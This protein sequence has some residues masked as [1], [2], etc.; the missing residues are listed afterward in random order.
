MK[1]LSYIILQVWVLCVFQSCKEETQTVIEPLP[2]GLLKDGD[3]AF[4]R[5]VGLMSRAVLV[6]DSKGIYSHVGLLKQIDG[7]WFVI[8]A[9]PD[10]P[11]FAGDVDRVKID[12]ITRFFETDRAVQGRVMRMS[13]SESAAREA[14]Q[15][16]HSM[17]RRHVLFDHRYDLSDTTAMYCTELVEFVYRKVGVDLAE[18]RLSTVNVPGMRG[19]YL[20]PSDLMANRKLSTICYFSR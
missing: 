5:G 20:L 9:V 12:S 6:A 8:H 10:E 7:S 18:G 19:R 15:I 1:Y 13:C 2:L 16:A 17:A 4:R 3:L 11:D 14:A